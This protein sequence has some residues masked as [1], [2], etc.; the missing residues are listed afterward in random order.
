MKV[1]SLRQR[2]AVESH[3]L[4]SDKYGTNSVRII[5]IME[6]VLT[7]FRV[8]R[9][10]DRNS[11]HEIVRKRDQIVIGFV[12]QNHLEIPISRVQQRKD[13]EH[14]KETVGHPPAKAWVLGDGPNAISAL[15]ERA[16]KEPQPEL[17]EDDRETMNAIRDYLVSQ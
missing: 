13:T 3:E 11:D 10:C 14:M 7:S 1:K 4:E 6:S 16:P 5:N 12:L 8:S 9:K 17:S 2:K 15:R